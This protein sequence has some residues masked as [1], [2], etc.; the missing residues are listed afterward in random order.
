MIIKKLKV[1]NYRTLENVEVEFKGY[2]T[3][4]SGKNN[5][6][7]S[8]IIR[9]IRGILNRGIRFRIRGG[10][11]FGMEGFDWND[12]VTNWKKTSKEDIS[13][14]L[15]IEIHKESDAAIYRFL[16]DFIFK[17][18]DTI[19]TSECEELKISFIKKSDNASAYKIFL[20]ERE[21]E[22]NY[23]KQEV[24]KRLKNTECLIFHNS[25]NRGFG[26]FDENPDRV[27][28]F[29]SANEFI[30]INQKRDELLKLVQKSLRSHQTE[31]TNLL[32][33]LEEK[34]EVSLSTRGLNFESESIDISLKE[35]GADISLDDWGS[36]TKNR[37]LIFLNILN[38]KRAQQMEEGM[39]SDKITPVILI[40][41]PE[42]FLHPQAQAEF[43]RILQDL[44]NNLQIQI[45]VTTHS[46]YL[47]CFKS[48]EANIL[49]E[50]DLKPKS[51]D[52]SS[53]IIDT[54]S[55]SW[56][57]PFV[58]ALGINATDFGPMKDLIFS[59]TP[60]IL[61][62][63]GPI[64]KEYFQYFQ[65][66]KF[67]TN[68]LRSD[69]EIFAYDGAD[70]AKNTILMNFIKKKFKKV[71]L[72]ADLDR[73]LDIKKSV[74]SIGFTENRDLFA[75]GKNAVGKRC[76]EGLIPQSSW[77]TVL[78]QN[79]ELAQIITLEN[80]KEQKSAKNEIKK[81]LLDDFKETP[82]SDTSHGDFYSII[83]KINKAFKD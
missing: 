32:G 15:S 60:K 35:K 54:H 10:S 37:T 64:D 77:S 61:L 65:D 8:N 4:I 6:G 31:L 1:Q 47:L 72:T 29:V 12:D 11:Y 26:P 75:I 59:E 73:Y 74:T 23:Q 7:K 3:A 76:I 9:V 78:S 46:P 56:Y 48:P 34:Y 70:N 43:G 24:L 69:I 57:E 5:A 38:A 19:R 68:A 17:D 28:N 39:E 52:T 42:S 82:I 79:S 22:D 62:V 40:E 30:K 50:R 45:I 63:E 21:I 13:I 25:T 33:N 55:D 27:S 44:A 18:I 14:E 51:K 83:K 81:K 36:G 67:S 58:N 20:G 71:V 49:L 66:E 2:Y 16:T 53:Q 41:E 80:G